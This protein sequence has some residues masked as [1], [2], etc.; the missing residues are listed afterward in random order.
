MTVR[1][2]VAIPIG[3][4]PELVAAAQAIAASQGVLAHVFGHA[5]IGILHVLILADPAER[6]RAAAARV[7][8]LERTLAL[9]GAVSGEHGMGLGNRDFA[10]RALGPA[11]DVMR[12]IKSVFDPHG[13]LN[14]GKI[15]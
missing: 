10:V 13:I 8:L 15:W 5:G 2:D 14:P 11:L 7:A 9:G 1:S 12:Q 3:A 6:P 4:L